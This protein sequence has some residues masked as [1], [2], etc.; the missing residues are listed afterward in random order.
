ME[1]YREKI[2]RRS[3]LYLS[4]FL[5]LSSGM[6]SICLNVDIKVPIYMEVCSVVIFIGLEVLLL[7]LSI[8]D[9]IAISSNEKLKN[10]YIKE[11]D[12]RKKYFRQSIGAPTTLIIYFILVIATVI[13]GFINK[14]V[15][16]TLIGINTI[17]GL[18]ISGIKIYY[19]RR[20]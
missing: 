11:N 4:T 19:L 10:Y 7:F 2:K 16:L 13:S 8:R 15:F 1:K 14:F 3:L 18:I 20:Y 12:E 9:R 17:M 6:L 5:G